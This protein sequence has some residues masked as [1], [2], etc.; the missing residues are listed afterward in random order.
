[1]AMPATGDEIGT[2]ASFSAKLPAQTVAIELEPCGTRKKLSSGLYSAEMLIIDYIPFDSN[3]SEI[4]RIE[5]GKS[6]GIMG[7]SAFSARAPC[8]ISRLLYEP[9]LPISPIA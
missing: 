8:P 5:K 4:N 7:K 2:P 1:M 6:D 3:T 9:T